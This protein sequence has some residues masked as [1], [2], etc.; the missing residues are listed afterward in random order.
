MHSMQ[1][2]VLAF[3]ASLCGLETSI[4]HF[5]V[6]MVVMLGCHH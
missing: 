3:I 4:G 5:V 6:V 1:D 2:F